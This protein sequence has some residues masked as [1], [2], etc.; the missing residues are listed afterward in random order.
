MAKIPKIKKTILKFFESNSQ[1]NV[2]QKVLDD[3]TSEN[4]NRFI[5]TLEKIGGSNFSF[6]REKRA[7][8]AISVVK[9]GPKT[10]PIRSKENRLQGNRIVG[11]DGEEARGE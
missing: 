4:R 8:R 3:C 10:G 11:L 2:S 9:E 6:S 5:S 1:E 7:R